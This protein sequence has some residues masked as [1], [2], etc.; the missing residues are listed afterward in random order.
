VFKDELLNM[1]P[2]D[3]RARDLGR[4]SMTTSDFLSTA[5]TVLDLEAALRGLTVAEAGAAVDAFFAGRECQMLGLSPLDFREVVESALAQ[6]SFRAA[7]R[8]LRGHWRGPGPNDAPT[9]VFLHD[10]LGSVRLWRDFPDQLVKATGCGALVYDRWGSGDAE[11]LAPPYA[12]DYLLREALES[13]PEVLEKTGVR[14]AIL[15]GQS[16]GASIALACAGARPERVR[17]VI[18][19][20]PHL[21]V[22]ERTRA[23]IAVQVRDFEKGDLKARLARHHG[24]NTEALFARL[25]EVWTAQA[26][27]ASW[28][29]EPYV[30]RVRRP[31]LAIQGEDDEFFSIAQLEALAA[32]LPGKLET[33]RIPGSAHYPMHQARNDVLAAS[34]RLIRAAAGVSRPS[35]STGISS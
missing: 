30:A 14:E 9:L 33:L 32:L 13:L 20:S 27:G 16:D 31:V 26:P 8:A 25:V 7:G 3:E 35:A 23:Q 12:P 15:I 21:F 22:E 29:L 6:L 2:G 18:A 28:G 19:L 11:P 34:I 10:A 4:R 5:R 24:A 17:G 1:I